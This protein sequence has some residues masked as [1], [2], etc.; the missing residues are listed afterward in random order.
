MFTKEELQR[1]NDALSDFLCWR[2]GYKAGIG[3][4][5]DY[6]GVIDIEGLRDLKRKLRKLAD[7]T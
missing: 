7:E 1:Y 4:G 5:Y 2:E 3:D 6:T